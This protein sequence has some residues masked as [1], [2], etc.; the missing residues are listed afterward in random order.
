MKSSEDDEKVFEDDHS[1][2]AASR[3]AP[4]GHHLLPSPR[5][6]VVAPQVL[7]VKKCNINLCISP[8]ENIEGKDMKKSLNEKLLTRTLKKKQV[9]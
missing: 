7:P 6:E 2:A 9:I 8:Y 5:G 4:A 1:V 3:R